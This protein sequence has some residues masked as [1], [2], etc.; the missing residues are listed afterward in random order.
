[1]TFP[2]WNRTICSLAVLIGI[3]WAGLGCGI[4]ADK[5]R[6]Q[7]AKI[8][9]RV[10]TRGDLRQAIRMLPP[11]EKPSIRTRGDVRSALTHYVDRQIKTME[12][13]SLEH[14]GKISVSEDQAAQY[15]FARHP[16][17]ASVYHLNDPA[18]LGMTKEDLKSAK[19]GVKEAIE[20]TR[21]KLLNEQAM[22][23]LIVQAYKSGSVKVSD[24]EWKKEY[25]IQ[26]SKL[27]HP[28]KDHIVG[29]A[30]HANSKQAQKDAA[31]IRRRLDK[32]AKVDDIAKD[33]VP[34]NRAG[35]IDVTVVNDG[36]DK[37]F[38]SF[39]REAASAQEGDVVGP[40]YIPASRRMIP[41]GRG[42]KQV[43][44]IPPMFLICKI[45]KITPESPMTLKE[46]KP[47]LAASIL[48]VHMLKQLRQKFDV[49]LYENN[50]WDPS[51]ENVSQNAGPVKERQNQQQAVP[52]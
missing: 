27:V 46:A 21:Q 20:R 10:I 12:A 38:A 28:M 36:R 49:K 39:W 8:G 7:V 52:Q 31:E 40:V 9:P 3:A 24:E 50:L 47:E 44:Q 26:K 13:K 18:Q 11:D 5:D 37:T 23:Y 30:V 19:Q 17:E 51:I 6:I 2:R 14:D 4:I 25:N 45:V 35:K 1:M 43:R 41:N 42:G 16:E 29:L 33:F 32:G 34:D 22:R 48:Y 15:Y